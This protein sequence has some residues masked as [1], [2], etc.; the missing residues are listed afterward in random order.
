LEGVEEEVLWLM[1]HLT[2]R[3]R[4]APSW[5]H[6]LN[7]FSFPIIGGWDIAQS[8]PYQA[9]KSWPEGFPTK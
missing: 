5:Q 7:I 3:L 1:V 8:G 4:I 9:S 6:I 2:K